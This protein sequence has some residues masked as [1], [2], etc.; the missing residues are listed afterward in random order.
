MTAITNSTWFYFVYPLLLIGSIFLGALIAKHKYHKK[1]ITWKP[2]G[3]ETSI[4][5]IFGLILSFTLNSSNTEYRNRTANLNSEADV[6]AQMRRASLFMDSSMCHEVKQYLIKF[7]AVH[8]NINDNHWTHEKMLDTVAHINGD[9][10]NYLQG[11]YKDS[12]VNKDQLGTLLRYHNNLCTH[13]YKNAFSYTERT[14]S[15]IMFLLI[16]GS[17]L[18]GLL[19]GFMNTFTL[20]YRSYLLPILYIFLTSLSIL[21][22][23]D[24]DN[25]KTGLI[26]PDTR[27]IQYLHERLLDS[28]R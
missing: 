2:A 15:T 4:V 19:V 14:P 9:F 11:M 3:L 25:P 21:G 18:I 5:S 13:F 22:I 24:M 28:D 12:T 8:A 16:V 23:C 1:S 17:L 7:T 20:G 6:A 10:V 26:Q 27:N